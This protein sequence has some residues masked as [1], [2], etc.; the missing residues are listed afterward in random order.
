[1]KIGFVSRPECPRCIDLIASLRDYLIREGNEVIVEKSTAEEMK[2]KGESIE[3]MDTEVVITVGGDG[4]ALWTLKRIKSAIL[5]INMG[6]LG[7]LSEVNPNNALQAL[8][9]LLR[10][11]FKIEE[12]SR[13]KTVLNSRRLGDSVN[14]VVIKTIKTSKIRWFGIY[15]DND[16]IH[17][18]RADG[19]II[20]TPT[21]STSYSLS[22]GGPILDPRVKGLIIS[23]IAPFSLNV[24][25]IVV[26]SESTIRVKILDKNKNLEMSMD[27]QEAIEV[28]YHDEITFTESET[29]ARFIRFSSDFYKNMREK[30]L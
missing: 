5:P 17:N 12:R 29:P 16:F 23:H 4:T 25:S 14:E 13:I 26:P 9:R 30:M 28:G 2:L 27:G 3:D 7:F 11:E 19:V 21:G 20:A 22:V 18:I 1:M 8:S 10:G 15:I 24:R 6:S